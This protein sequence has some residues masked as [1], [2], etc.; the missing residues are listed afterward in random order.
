VL[1]AEIALS[2]IKFELK[3]ILLIKGGFK[4]GISGEDTK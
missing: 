1:F 2:I 3:K 4:N